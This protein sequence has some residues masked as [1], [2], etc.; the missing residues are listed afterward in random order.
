[1]ATVE[2]SATI[3]P[4]GNHR[5]AIGNLFAPVSAAIAVLV[6][7]GASPTQAHVTTLNTALT[8]L[9]AKDVVVLVNTSNVTTKNRYRDAVA[10]IHR[11][12]NSFNLFSD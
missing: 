8:A 5:A 1:M 12:V 11:V 6:A 9:V 3:D 7:D 10:A 4:S 2:F